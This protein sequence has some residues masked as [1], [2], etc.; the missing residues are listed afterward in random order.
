MRPP[1]IQG[2]GSRPK[3]I[4]STQRSCRT[5]HLRREA[6]DRVSDL[7]RADRP[8]CDRGLGGSFMSTEIT[9]FIPLASRTSE[10]TDFPTIAFRSAARDLA[11]D[12][13]TDKR[14]R[15]MSKAKALTSVRSLARSHTRTAISVLAKIM[16][17]EDATPAARVSAANALLD[18]GWGRATHILGS[19]DYG[20]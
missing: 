1:Y 9:R 11:K 13:E 8:D 10:Q 3:M 17:S 2:Y 19:C 20:A 14:E 6:D 5:F 16:R 4:A 15:K 18:G 7:A 12:T